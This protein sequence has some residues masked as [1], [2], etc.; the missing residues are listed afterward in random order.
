MERDA[1][2]VHAGGARLQNQR[3][4]LVLVRAVLGAEIDDAAF[5]LDRDAEQDAASGA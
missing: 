1:A 2:D 3:Q 4:R 5:I